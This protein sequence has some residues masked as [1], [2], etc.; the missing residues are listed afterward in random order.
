MSISQFTLNLKSEGD[1]VPN[2]FVIVGT[3]DNTGDQAGLAATADQIVGITTSSSLEFDSD[4]HADANEGTNRILLQEGRVHFVKTGDAV[5][6]GDII[7]TDAAGLAIPIGATVD[8]GWTAIEA[9]VAAGE[10]IK[11]YKR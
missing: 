7:A 1:I 10:I 9:A 5:A 4:L 11:V 2:S 8:S 6:V 3:G